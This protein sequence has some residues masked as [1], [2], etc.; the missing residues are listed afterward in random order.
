MMEQDMTWKP[1]F[2]VML[3]PRR[4]LCMHFRQLTAHFLLKPSVSSTELRNP[5]KGLLFNQVSYILANR[6]KMGLKVRWAW[7][8]VCWPKSVLIE[9]VWY[10]A[11]ETTQFQITHLLCCPTAGQ[12]LGLFAHLLLMESQAWCILSLCFTTTLCLAIPP[13]PM[14]SLWDPTSIDS[15]N[16]Y[17]VV[18]M[19]DPPF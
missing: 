1:V 8:R 10:Q 14:L 7:K 2:R 4:L 12:A 18:I 19:C 16:I 11:M 9:K 15:P 3:W 17:W 13:S 6:N 5:S